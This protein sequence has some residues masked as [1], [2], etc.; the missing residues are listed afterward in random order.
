MI[1]QKTS[2]QAMRG[3]L[4]EQYEDDKPAS[5]LLKEVKEARKVLEIEKKVKPPKFS[6]NDFEQ[7]YE[8][9]VGWEWALLD[10][11]TNIRRGASPRP[12]RNFITESEDGVPWIKIG[13]SIEGS[14]YITSTRE[15][16]TKEGAKKSVYLEVGS[17]IMSNS[18]SYGKAYILGIDGCIHDGWLSFELFN[19]SLSNELLLY[20]LNGSFKQFEDKA[21]G[22]G[23]KN[24]NIDRVRQTLLPIPPL[25]EQKRIVDKIERVMSLLEEIERN[26]T[27]L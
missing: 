21:V 17:L 10:E 11:I 13:D 16:V 3:E 5:E 22:T 26:A 25:N 18:M 15:R 19:D 14:K 4:V 2:E 20:F 9:P 1:R 8:L 23:V 24:L 7:P 12:I 27:D 6:M